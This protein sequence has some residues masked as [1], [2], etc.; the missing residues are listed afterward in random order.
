MKDQ[1]TETANR[2]NTLIQTKNTFAV[3]A[4]AMPKVSSSQ[5]STMFA[6]KKRYT[7]GMKRRRGRRA[8]S[9][10]NSGSTASMT[11]KVAVNSQ[12][13]FLMPPASPISSRTGRST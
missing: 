3:S 10:P 11:T 5:N 13:R 8:T 6:P 4:I 1:K 7:S 12:G 2:L 9:A